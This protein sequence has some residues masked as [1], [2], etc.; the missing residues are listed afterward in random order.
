MGLSL[1]SLLSATNEILRQRLFGLKENLDRIMLRS[2]TFDSKLGEILRTIS[3]KRGDSDTINKS[4]SSNDLVIEKFI[5]F[6][7]WKPENLTFETKVSFKNLALDG[8]KS[9]TGGE[10][11]DKPNPS[12]SL[13][14][15]AILFPPRPDS[16]LDAAALKVQKVYKSYRTRRNLADCAV[17]VEELWFVNISF[18]LF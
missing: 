11:F 4:K 15:P 17:V 1:S 10:L 16:E 14:Q 3:F 8:G 2:I 5:N 9:S 12:K 18:D 7:K 13:P 6:K